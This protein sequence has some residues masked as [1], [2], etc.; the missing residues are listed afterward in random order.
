MQR[1]DEIRIPV[2]A[3]ATTTALVYPV[4]RGPAIATLILAHGAGAGQRHPFMVAFAE[5]IARL[6]IDVVTFNFVYTE[7]RRRIP[8]RA[9]VL[10]ACFGA[11]LNHVSTTVPSA[12]RGLFIGGKSMGG[13]IATQLA[14]AD[15]TL[16][17][18]GIILL[19]YPLHPP[20]RPDQRRDAHLAR[21]RAPMLFVQ[22]SRDAFGT[23][24]ELEPALAALDR[25]TL[26]VVDGGDHSFK[27]ARTDSGRQKAVYAE[28]QRTVAEWIQSVF[29]K[30]S[31]SGLKP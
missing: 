22:G 3:G 26:R 7:Q 27:L 16:P 20:G 15:D 28:I 12:T 9:P 19:G 6:G 24:V 29:S 11:V 21:V 1:S 17:V 23:P 30:T 4:D 31:P 25:A 2:M 5:A 18:A 10:E 14:A 8:D 13:R